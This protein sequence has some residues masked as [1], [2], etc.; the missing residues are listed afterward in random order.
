MTVFADT[1]L[2]VS[3]CVHVPTCL[4]AVRVC[5]FIVGMSLGEIGGVS[6]CSVPACSGNGCFFH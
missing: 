3:V 4:P 1:Y 6:L 5:G 2:S